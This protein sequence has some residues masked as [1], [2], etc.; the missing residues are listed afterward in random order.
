MKYFLLHQNGVVR[1]V[2]EIEDNADNAYLLQMEID[3]PGYS[4]AFLSKT[5]YD[6]VNGFG[7]YFTYTN[8]KLTPK[9][10]KEKDK[11]DAGKKIIDKE[12]DLYSKVSKMEEE[13]EKLKKKPK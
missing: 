8:N 9:D 3:N 2:G 4:A 12:N 5:D 13:I 10:K 7:E 1:I 6:S 11:I